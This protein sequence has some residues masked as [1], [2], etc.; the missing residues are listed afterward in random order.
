MQTCNNCG[1][2]F[3][4]DKAGLVT[5]ERGNPVAAVCGRCCTDVRVGKIVVRQ[6][7]SRSGYA[8]DQWQP[9][10]VAGGAAD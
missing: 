1:D 6:S 10:E 2:S 5:T 8:Y 9:T 7:R 3:D 4:E